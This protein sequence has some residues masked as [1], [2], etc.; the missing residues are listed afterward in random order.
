MGARS[1]ALPIRGKGSINSVAMG[2]SFGLGWTPCFGP[3]LASILVVA[4]T[5]GSAG[6]GGTLLGFYSLGLAI[7][8]LLTGLFTD[9]ASAIIA[10]NKSGLK[11]LNDV[12]GIFLLVLGVIVFTNSF[13][14]L[15]AIIP[16]LSGL[17]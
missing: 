13:A 11:W 10:K 1:V 4:G 2:A 15:L 12:S 17:G 8:F 3:I 9:K 16:G 7:P 6:V 14:R 5:A